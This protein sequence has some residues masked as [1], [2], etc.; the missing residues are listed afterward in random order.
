MYDTVA[1][2]IVA[3]S[4]EVMACVETFFTAF[5]TGPDLDQRLDALAATFLP[6]A[7]VAHFTATGVLAVDGVTAF[8][9]PRRSYLTGDAVSEFREWAL[10]GQVQV[11]GDLAVWSGAYAK[12]GR[13][14]DGRLAG[15][16]F[17]VI[18]LVRLEGVWRI[19]HVAWQD[20]I[21]AV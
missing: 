5:A 12:E 8:I 20:D 17:K 18:Q 9:E 21:L 7:T 11:H 6:E 1:L 3:D 15:S 4:D 19:A 10:P 2:M 16:G 13:G 14:V